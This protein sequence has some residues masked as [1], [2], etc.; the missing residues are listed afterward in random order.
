L[1][2][3]NWLISLEMALL[4][5]FINLVVG[6]ALFVVSFLLFSPFFFIGLASTINQTASIFSIILIPVIIIILLTMVIGSALATFQLS[7][8]TL[9]YIRLTEGGKAHSKI[10]RWVATMPGKFMKKG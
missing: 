10:V 2:S 3:A 4:L 9:L 8:W 1:F 5:L 7:S 6:F